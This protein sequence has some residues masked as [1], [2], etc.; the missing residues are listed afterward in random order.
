[1]AE[2]FGTR[3]MRM[4]GASAAGE[5]GACDRLMM[6]HGRWVTVKTKDGYVAESLDNQLAVTRSLGL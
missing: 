2:E 3:C 4:G 1:M 5:V 6:K